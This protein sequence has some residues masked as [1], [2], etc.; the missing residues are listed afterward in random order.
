M[1]REISCTQHTRA[2]AYHNF[3][4]FLLQEKRLQCLNF[5]GQKER[6]WQL[7]SLIRYI[8]VVGGPPDR[9]GLLL[10]LKDGQVSNTV[11]GLG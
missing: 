5:S 6:E 2:R 3:D 4:F 7:D 11:Q 10:G 1:S 9:E 8:K